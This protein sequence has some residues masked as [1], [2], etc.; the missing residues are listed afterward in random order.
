[1]ISEGSDWLKRLLIQEHVLPEEIMASAVDMRAR[2][3]VS[4]CVQRYV[5]CEWRE[6]CCVASVCCTLGL[7]MFSVM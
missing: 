5:L 6:C 1:M 7:M 2:V 4:L 3:C